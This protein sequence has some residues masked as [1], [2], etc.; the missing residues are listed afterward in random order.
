MYGL[1]GFYATLSSVIALLDLGLTSTLNRELAILSSV[2]GSEEKMR[3]K[4]R[5][6][7]YVYWITG[8]FIGLVVYIF[9][10]LISLYINH[11]SLSHE[12]LAEAIFLMGIVIGLKWPSS[13]YIGGLLGLQRHVV[14][15]TWNLILEITKMIATVVC[16]KYIKATIEVFFLVQVAYYFIYSVVF[17]L[18]LWR[19]LPSA[20]TKP[21]YVKK[22]LTEIWRFASGM[23]GISIVSIILTQV[24][25][26]VLIRLLPLSGFGYYSLASSISSGLYRVIGPIDQS[27]YPKIVQLVSQKNDEYLKKTYHKACQFMAI[28][29]LPG[30]FFLSFFSLDFVFLW[31]RNMTTTSEVAPLVSVLIIGTAFH[32]LMFVPYALQLA[33]GWTKFALI[34][35]IISIVVLAPVMYVFTKQYGAL[36]AALVWVILNIGYI[37]VAQPI[38]YKKLLPSEK[39]RWYK[40]DFFIPL[41]A[42]IGTALLVKLIATAFQFDSGARYFLLFTGV[43]ATYAVAVGTT[44]STRKLAYNLIGKPK[45]E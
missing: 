9:S 24:D 25:K 45:Y 28:A 15:N 34:Q 22:E 43:L 5:T 4:V 14:Y 7:E 6:L 16:L 42:S 1:V 11:S 12:E 18:L 33:Y 44:A 36:G 40:E 21:K 38:M 17:G 31:T 27:F 26:A 32:G 37:F 20:N 10:G 2:P 41:I 8:I 35:N 13:L 30:A 3:N 29:I 39:N 23:T 19:N